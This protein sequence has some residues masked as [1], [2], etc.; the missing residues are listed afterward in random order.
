MRTR[1]FWLSVTI[2]LSSNEKMPPGQ[3][4]PVA[5]AAAALLSTGDRAATSLPGETPRK[6]ASNTMP[7]AARTLFA[8]TDSSPTGTRQRRLPR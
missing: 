1:C 8:S 3:V 6:V 7:V 2:N 4:I 5:L